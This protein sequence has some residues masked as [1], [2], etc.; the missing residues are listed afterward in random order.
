LTKT[1]DISI[2][3]FIYPIMDKIARNEELTSNERILWDRFDCDCDYAEDNQ[4]HCAI[5]IEF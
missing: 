4:I 1:I 2:P 3:K 5:P